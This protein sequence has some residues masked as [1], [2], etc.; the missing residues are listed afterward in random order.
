[1]EFVNRFTSTAARLRYDVDP[2]LLTCPGGS[3]DD[4]LTVVLSYLTFN[5][6]PDQTHYGSTLDLGNKS[7]HRL[8]TVFGGLNG[9]LLCMHFAK[10]EV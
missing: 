10:Y 4:L 2:S 8:S 9:M 3:F 7:L 5:C 1:M 6:A